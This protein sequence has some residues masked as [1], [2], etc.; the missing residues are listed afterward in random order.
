MLRNVIGF[1]VLAT[2][3][4]HGCGSDDP[5]LMDTCSPSHVPG[6][7][8]CKECSFQGT[9]FV[10]CNNTYVLCTS[11]NC[12]PSPTDVSS[13]YCRCDVE[14]GLSMRFTDVYEQ[15]LISNFSFAQFPLQEI[16]CENANYI[17]CLGAPCTA[18]GD[19]KAICE[20]QLTPNAGQSTFVGC[21]EST[22]CS[23]YP[24]RSGVQ[25]TTSSLNLSNALIQAMGHHPP[26][27]TP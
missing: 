13:A 4:F 27:C 10:L 21:S 16:N 5:A 8:T 18:I 22:D 9:T 26:E 19:N 12:M 6:A 15:G 24:F 20:C 14:T 23:M 7:G 11:A 2:I 3:V 25:L 17:D 1:A